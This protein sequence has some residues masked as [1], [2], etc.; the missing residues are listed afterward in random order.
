MPKII[1]DRQGNKRCAKCHQY[2]PLDEFRLNKATKDGH[3]AY[4][5]VCN[6]EILHSDKEVAA[7]QRLRDTEEHKAK[8]NQAA[9]G[10]YTAHAM[11]VKA[12]GAVQIATR[13]G[14]LTPV[15]KC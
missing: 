2:K 10:Y 11:E 8:H 4:C 14:K 9:K 1:R 5:K 12:R 7:R 3:Y 6:R 13:N 15:S